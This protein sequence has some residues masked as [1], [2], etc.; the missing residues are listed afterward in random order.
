MSRRRA[1]KIN[2]ILDTHIRR[3]D[4]A[5]VPTMTSMLESC[6]AASRS[7]RRATEIFVAHIRN[8][9]ASTSI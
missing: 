7:S 2:A 8:S 9:A 3:D 5:R 4:A 1:T 6:A